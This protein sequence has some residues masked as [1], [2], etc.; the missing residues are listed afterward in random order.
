MTIIIL[1]NLATKSNFCTCLINVNAILQTDTFSSVYNISVMGVK[2]AIILENYYHKPK[3]L[4]LI[5]FL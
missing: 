5:Y 4:E 2:F 3:L 1:S